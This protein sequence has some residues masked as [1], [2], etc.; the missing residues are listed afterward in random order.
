[1]GA[2]PSAGKMSPRA[3]DSG[4]GRVRRRANAT[5]TP[6][7]ALS[8][9]APQPFDDLDAQHGVQEFQR[10][11]NA[12]PQPHEAQAA[13]GVAGGAQTVATR[14]DVRQR[15][16]IGI[17]HVDVKNTKVLEA[18]GVLQE[19]DQAV[20]RHRQAGS[21]RQRLKLRQPAR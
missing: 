11:G 18:H 8:G 9:T 7:K 6:C 16:A 5:F 4:R 10:Q 13:S 17:G 12:K 1:M 20:V 2:L 3:A 21:R 19:S 15:L 14:D